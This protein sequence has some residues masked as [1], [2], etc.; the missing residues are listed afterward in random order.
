M[1]FCVA[2]ID[3]TLNKARNLLDVDFFTSNLIVNFEIFEMQYLSSNEYNNFRINRFSLFAFPS[4]RIMDH[5][6][7]LYNQ[8]KS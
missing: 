1:D 6:D 3:E 5:A 7:Y 2:D 4:G 8:A